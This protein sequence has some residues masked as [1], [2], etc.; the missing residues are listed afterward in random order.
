MPLSV[1]EKLGPYQILALIGAGGMGEVYR[2][3]DTRLDRDVALKIATENFTARFEQEARSIAAL[4][5]PNICH[6]YDVGPNYLV[7]ELIDGAPLKGP[8]PLEKALEYARQILDALDSAH[9]KGITHRDL[10]P[11]NILV[12]K[13]GIKLLDFGLAKRSGTLAETDATRALTQD[14]AIVGTL[15]YMSPEQLQ[16][17][18]ADARSDIFAF[19]LI[20]YEIITGKRAFDGPSAASVVAA[21]L[22]R[23]APSISQVAP[24]WLD[25][26]LQLAVEKEPDRRWQSARDVC[27]ALDLAIVPG[28]IKSIPRAPF[29]WIAASVL[30]LATTVFAF[31]YFRPHAEPLVLNA[32]ILP[33]EGT[34]LDFT[35]GLG[36]PALSP[37]GRKIVFGART[38]DGHA[39]LWVRPLDSLKPQPIAGTDGAA[40]P[41]WSPDSRSIGFFAEGKLKRID[42]SGG[43]ALVLADA[44][45]AR[46][47]S[48]SST[49]VII[50]A[51]SNT[52]GLLRVSASG[53]SATQIDAPGSRLPWF[54]PDGEHFVYEYQ[55]RPT[56]HDVTIRLGTLNGGAS[57]DLL[58]SNSNAVYSQGYLLYIRDGTLMARGFDA[59]RLKIAP[60]EHPAA[61][62]VGAVLPS[63]TAGAFSVSENGTLAYRAGAEDS[64]VRLAWFDRN[65]KQLSTIDTPIALVGYLRL[66]PDGKVVALS[67]EER[68]N[69]DVW[70]IDL[71]TGLKTRFTFDPTADREP[72][73][74]PDQKKIVFSSFRGGKF[75]DLYEKS[76]NGAGADELLYE[77]A[78]NKTALCWSPDG[79]ILL[80][81]VQKP[82][83]P[84]EI[85]ALPIDGNPAGSGHKP[86]PVIQGPGNAGFAQFSPDGKWIAYTSDESSLNEVFVV[87]FPNTKGGKYLIGRAALS[88]P[89]WRKDGKELF[90][91]SG[92]RR[93]MSA[94][95]SI[96]SEAIT[97]G[98]VRALFGPIAE[99]PG[100]TTFEAESDGQ[101]F[102]V[103]FIAGRKVSEPITV[104]QNWISALDK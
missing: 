70:T 6:V 68:S 50:F 39:P 78:S 85:W 82:T 23:P 87:P 97:V 34:T 101:R 99:A 52:T 38:T 16:S 104:V 3:R 59:R 36:L 53:G 81:V 48:W 100:V 80:Y 98:Q 60:D 35:N 102:L 42:A 49:G 92:D 66:S 9:S 44:T 58:R 67:A 95:L 47:G 21:I 19:G 71:A 22:E 84:A 63:R 27:H 30:G 18:S 14:G 13:Q 69:I 54:L 64:V 103:P 57:T 8:L 10:K 96:K 88:A 75:I 86:Y 11:A 93:I 1:G 77:D 17:N 5:H 15:S 89:R 62:H 40:F 31:L 56:D 20:L 32:T 37:D 79:K 41:F 65:G 28:I 46:G 45:N 43:P 94:E 76:S 74:S 25:R 4:N 61:D 2:A 24:P 33:A 12:T 90:F 29:G 83:A 51:P 26:I 72:T 55:V 91:V 73:W 7:M